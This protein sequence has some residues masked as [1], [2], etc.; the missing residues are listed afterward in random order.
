MRKRGP[1]NSIK[2][3]CAVQSTALNLVLQSAYH[4]YARLLASE[5]KRP[6]KKNMPTSWRMCKNPKSSHTKGC[7]QK[8]QTSDRVNCAASA[9]MSCLVHGE[10][11]MRKNMRFQR[12]GYQTNGCCFRVMWHDAPYL[13][14][15]DTAYIPPVR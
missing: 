15:A 6:S 9:S 2:L 7:V 3:A 8:G 4:A 11:P 10:F 13:L 5:G 12:S 1:L 14:H